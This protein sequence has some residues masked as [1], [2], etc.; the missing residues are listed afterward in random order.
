MATLFLDAQ[1]TSTTLES[2]TS[3]VYALPF[4]RYAVRLRLTRAYVQRVE[5]SGALVK[6]D[7]GLTP[8]STFSRLKDVASAVGVKPARVEAALTPRLKPEGRLSRG[9]EREEYPL[10]PI[11]GVEIAARCVSARLHLPRATLPLGSILT[12]IPGINLH[13]TPWFSRGTR[14][15]FARTRAG[16]RRQVRLPWTLAA[17]SSPR[18]HRGSLSLRRATT[19]PKGLENSATCCVSEAASTPTWQTVASR[20]SS[21]VS[22]ARVECDAPS[23]L[24]E[25]RRSASLPR[26]ASNAFSQAGP[27]TRR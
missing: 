19:A 27:S 21:P 12:N 13:R 18:A 8:W 6:V 10:R 14:R 1:R 9:Q 20:V 17:G 16:G 24:V 5:A 3:R 22:S 4:R 7:D 25:T 2:S 23:T 11:P 26:R 15:T